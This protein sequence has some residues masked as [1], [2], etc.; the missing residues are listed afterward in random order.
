MA[1]V[2]QGVQAQ[3]QAPQDRDLDQQDPF[4]ESQPPTASTVAPRSPETPQA[5]VGSIAPASPREI[6]I[7][8]VEAAEAKTEAEQP[9][10]LALSVES[11]VAVPRFYATSTGQRCWIQMQSRNHRRADHLLQW[12]PYPRSV[13]L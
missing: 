7:P 8:S 1:E 10:A 4:R 2:Q 5:A 13:R 12:H 11:A 3:P 9:L 6:A